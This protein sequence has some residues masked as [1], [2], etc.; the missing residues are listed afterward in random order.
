[1]KQL[2]V[3]AR[4]LLSSGIGTYLR[5]LLP[6]IEHSDFKMRL[7]VNVDAVA[8]LP[9]LTRFDLIIAN[10]PIYSID[11][12]LKLPLLIPRC[13]VFWSPHYN[14]PL[15]PIK[16]KERLVT[17]HDVNHIAFAKHLSL[18]ERLYAK[19]VMKN[20]V[21]RS[22]KVITVSE[23]SKK[24]ICTHLKTHAGKI[25]VILPG[26]DHKM[27]IPREDGLSLQTKKHLQLPEKFFLF[28]G[29]VK[30]HKNLLGLLKGFLSVIDSLEDVHLLIV[31]KRKDFLHADSASEVFAEHPKL[32][33][34]VRF[35]DYVEDEYLPSLYRLAIAAILP[36]FYEG[37]GLPA[38]EA[39]S[40]GCAVAVSNVASLPEVCSDAAVYFDP[41]RPEEIGQVMK[42]LAQRKELLAEL[43][44]KGLRRSKEFCWDKCAMA[45][46]R[47]LEGLCRE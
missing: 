40:S 10:I 44:E 42:Q 12:Q 26:V 22:K 37:F 13:E 45:H 32:R 46:S 7:I 9:W 30:P 18:K 27:F 16:A 33:D 4:M 29:N 34:K 17:V 36:S 25:E 28:V 3:D 23:F 20:A 39:M 8:S 5:N 21:R 15:L 35:L 11:E 31:G 14:I 24:E 19:T 2:C 6:R 43:K 38:V 1:M 47:V 41:H